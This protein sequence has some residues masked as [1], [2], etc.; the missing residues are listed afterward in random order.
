MRRQK[1]ARARHPVYDPA[2]TMPRV[3][4]LASVVWLLLVLVAAPAGAGT[5]GLIVSGDPAKQP[6]IETTLEPWLK[7]AG[8]DVR[9]R[10][11]EQKEV[12]KIVDCFIL[13]DQACAEST[14]AGAG[15]AGLLFVMVEVKRDTRSQKDE[16]KLTGWLFSA[17]GKALVAQS[18]YC[19][20]CR[21]DTLGPTAEDLARALFSQSATGAG[22]IAVSTT[23]PGARVSVDGAPVGATPIE[24]GLRAGPHVV[25]V[26]LDGF[27]PVRRDV[28]VGK[29]KTVALELTMTP[30]D[31]PLPGAK[32]GPLPYVVLV[33]GVALA[34]A[35]VTLYLMDQ[36]C[37]A[38]GPCDV[39]NTQ[40]TF[41]N[42]APLGVGL[43][44]AGAVAIGVGAYLTLKAPKSPSGSASRAPAAVPVGWVTPGGGGVGVSTRF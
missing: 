5:M 19:R 36:D 17:D 41:R 35:G 3:L 44:A 14:V 43:A 42:S 32:R 9:L 39:P 21:N 2:G 16:V 4:R 34:G 33:G 22:R 1:G 13:T 12:D 27:H 15:V 40:E 24:H 7:K 18:V 25:D 38:G 20:D 11:L 8:Y 31:Q 10:V 23:P 6:V 30:A 28:D 37:E 29:D 26:T